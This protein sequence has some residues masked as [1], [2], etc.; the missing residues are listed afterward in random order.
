MFPTPPSLSRGEPREVGGIR[1]RNGGGVT[2]RRCGDRSEL[3]GLLGTQPRCPRHYTLI[4]RQPGSQFVMGSGCSPSPRSGRHLLRQIRHGGDDG[5]FLAHGEVLYRVRLEL[6]G[7]T[8]EQMEMKMMLQQMACKQR[9]FQMMEEQKECKHM[10][11]WPARCSNRWRLNMLF[12]ARTHHRRRP[13]YPSHAPAWQRGV[14]TQLSPC[15]AAVVCPHQPRMLQPQRTPLLTTIT[16]KSD[17][18]HVRSEASE[19]K[20]GWTHALKPEDTG[21][22]RL[23]K[24]K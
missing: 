12:V 23:M 18:H 21:G 8:K 4:R 13:G 6:F 14:V 1:R 10:L 24:P 20:R 7:Q 16:V 2:R 5:C 9:V 11:R 17:V 19:G 22:G 15:V 3:A